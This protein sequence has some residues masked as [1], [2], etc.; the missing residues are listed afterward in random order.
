MI[1]NDFNTIK[2]FITS[3]D[4]KTRFNKGK[5]WSFDLK[6]G[7]QYFKSGD[8]TPNK[9]DKENEY[10]IINPGKFAIL[11]TEE[12]INMP[13]THMGF[14]NVKF[15]YKKKGL[16]NVSGFHVDP[17]YSGKIIFT[18]FNAGPNDIFIHKDDYVFMIF[19]MKLKTT[20]T[21]DYKLCDKIN[22]DKSESSDNTT[23]GYDNIPLEMFE[24]MSGNSLTLMENN[25]RIEQLEFNMKAVI[26]PT[27]FVVLAALIQYLL[28]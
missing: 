15:S 7:E 22:Q 4:I 20:Y 9:L 23:K 13:S 6:I 5:R 16:I 24:H 28:K 27:V 21:K 18:V 8:N 12:T 26:V 14:I 17:N 25:K 10:L 2:E 11:L 3:D 19:F 1:D